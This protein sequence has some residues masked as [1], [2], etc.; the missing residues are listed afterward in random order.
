MR[1]PSPGPHMAA[2]LRRIRSGER[3]ENAWCS[4]RLRAVSRPIDRT[5][6]FCRTVTYASSGNGTSNHLRLEALKLKAG[7]DIL[8]IPYRG[9]A[10]AL[11]D[12][13]PGNVHMQNEPITLPHVKAGKLVLLVI[14]GPVRNPDFPD[15]PTLTEVGITGADVP[16]LFGFYGPTGIPKDIV[17][18]INAKARELAGNDD[19]KKKMWSVNAI[20]P[21][22]TPEEMSKAI[23]EDS[24]TNLEFIKAGNIKIE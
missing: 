9:G 19:F 15:V 14:N 17:D 13:L 8:H 16:I 12:V 3:R 22:Q 5:G 7:L 10:D 21:V 23:A 6:Q 11:N 18:K 24:K 4:S 2:W 20:L 1:I